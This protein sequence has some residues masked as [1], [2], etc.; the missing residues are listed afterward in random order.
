[1]CQDCVMEVI[2]Q[3]WREFCNNFGKKF[4][5]KKDLKYCISLSSVLHVENSSDMLKKKE[6]LMKNVSKTSE[7]KQTLL[8]VH[9]CEKNFSNFLGGIILIKV[10]TIGKLTIKNILFVIQA[11]KATT[12]IKTVS[13]S[14]KSILT[15]MYMTIM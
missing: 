2:P 13:D 6:I 5:F 15:F 12:I 8:I 7:L 14:V 3:L 10:L 11:M 1:M 4:V 9:F